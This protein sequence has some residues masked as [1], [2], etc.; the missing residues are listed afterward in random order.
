V[1]HPHFVT[2]HWELYRD[3]YWTLSRMQYMLTQFKACYLLL[4][5]FQ[6]QRLR[7]IGL[8]VN[9][10]NTEVCLFHEKW[11]LLCSNWNTGASN[12][13]QN[14]NECPKSD[15]QIKNCADLLQ[16]NHTIQKLF[17]QL[18]WYGKISVQTN[19]SKL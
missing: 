19:W 4:T 2:S 6:C 10:A 11:S 18:S 15:I 17:T 12:Y 13:I 7:Q 16:V 3:W 9:K 5:Q 8:K 1:K 14:I